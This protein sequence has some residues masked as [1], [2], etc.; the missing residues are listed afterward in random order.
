LFQSRPTDETA[1]FTVHNKM[2]K[3]IL[4]LVSML[5]LFVCTRQFRAA[6]ALASQ[7]PIPVS[8]KS[9]EHSVPTRL[10]QNSAPAPPQLPPGGPLDTNIFN[11]NGLVVPSDVKLLI[12]DLRSNLDQ[13]NPLLS[14]LNGETPTNAPATGASPAAPPTPPLTPTG[15]T[16]SGD[17]TTTNNSPLVYSAGALLENVQSDLDALLPRLAAMVGH[18]NYAGYNGGTTDSSPPTPP[19]DA[20]SPFPTPLSNN[21]TPPLT[22]AFAPPLIQGF[23]PPLDGAAGTTNPPPSTPTQ[24]PPQ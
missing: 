2:K 13:V 17:N 21:I 7:S 16:P 18:T 20:N 23:A 5:A 1:Q 15:P 9:S 4:I 22:N 3:L 11:T 10:A 14:I 6:L 19:D 12:Q 8:S 24:K